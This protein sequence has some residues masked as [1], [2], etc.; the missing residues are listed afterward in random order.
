MGSRRAW[1]EH[2]KVILAEWAT[3]SATA[4]REVLEE[5]CDLRAEFQRDRDRIIHS[6]AFR[7]LKDKTQVFLSPENDH[8]RVRLTH[9][10]EVTQIGRTIARL[11]RLNED[12]TEAICLGHDLGHTPFGHSG[13]DALNELSPNGFR[14]NEQSVRVC[15]KEKLNLTKQVRDGIINHSGDRQAASLEGLIVKYADRIAYINHDIDDSVREGVLKIEDLPESSVRILGASR[16][17]RIDTLVRAIVTESAGKP[18]VL[19]QPD[20]EEEMLKLR[21]FMFDNVYYKVNRPIKDI[22]ERLY[23]HYMAKGDRSER[24]VCDYIAGMTD[25]YAKKKDMEIKQK[26]V[27]KR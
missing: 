23:R 22:I 24:E 12:L 17:E 10:M 6:D 18:Q 1:E 4:E 21:K 11:L 9:T 25:S 27:F 26:R 13:E 20:I 19:M 5:P 14:H 16:G 8:H 7:R 2:E 3:F 15:E